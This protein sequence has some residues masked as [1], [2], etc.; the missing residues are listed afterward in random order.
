MWSGSNHRRLG[1]AV[2]L[3]DGSRGVG[4]LLQDSDGDL[5]GAVAM[6][7]PNMLPVLATELYAMKSG[8]SVAA[9]ASFVPLILESDTLITVNLVNSECRL[10]C[11]GG[12]TS[13]RNS[14]TT[15]LSTS[16]VR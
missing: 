11:C 6:A 9:D 2:D 14:H 13:G 16:G 10:F 12:W 1:I 5:A 15:L 8:L 4:I 3:N 7:A